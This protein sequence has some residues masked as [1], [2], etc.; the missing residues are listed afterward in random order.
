MSK[1]RTIKLLSPTKDTATRAGAFQLL[2]ERGD[3]PAIVSQPALNFKQYTW[4]LSIEND[5]PVYQP[6][7]FVNRKISMVMGTE[8]GWDLLAIDQANI[9]NPNITTNLSY[10]WKKNDSSIYE[11]NRANG[12]VGS[13]DAR[14]PKADST[15]EV[16][17]RYVCEVANKFGSVTSEPFDI[18]VIDLQN[19]PKLYTN[20]ILNGDG[21]GGTDGWE[22]DSDIKTAA[23]IDNAGYTHQFGSMPGFGLLGKD[24]LELGG[25]D[26]NEFFFSSA[27][28]EGLFLPL[29]NKRRNN[30]P[31]FAAAVIDTKKKSDPAKVLNVNEQWISHILPQIISNEDYDKTG[32]FAAFFPGIA[33]LDAYNKNN[34]PNTIS[35]FAEFVNSNTGRPH[36]LTYFTRERIKFAKY[37]GKKKVQFSQTIDVSDLATMIDGQVLGVQYLS[38]HF[39]A[40]M[41]AGLSGYNITMETENDGTVTFPYFIAESEQ[42]Y[43]RLVNQDSTAFDSEVPKLSY[44]DLYLNQLD[45]SKNFADGLVSVAKD[46]VGGSKYGNGTFDKESMY[47]REVFVDF[48][49][50]ATY[51]SSQKDGV[52]PYFLFN[53]FD[54]HIPFLEPTITP[55]NF[56]DPEQAFSIRN[57][58]KQDPILGH[59]WEESVQFKPGGEKAFH[60]LRAKGKIRFNIKHMDGDSFSWLSAEGDLKAAVCLNVETRDWNATQNKYGPWTRLQ[61]TDPSKS[62]VR[63]FSIERYNDYDFDLQFTSSISAG[64]DMAHPRQ[65]RVL[66]TQD[67]SPK[68]GDGFAA[69]Q[70]EGTTY[71]LKSIARVAFKTKYTDGSFWYDLPYLV[72]FNDR[73]FIP[74]DGQNNKAR[75]YKANVPTY[76]HGDGTEDGTGT[77]FEK[78]EQKVDM[79]VNSAVE[80]YRYNTFERKADPNPGSKVPNGDP[81]GNYYIVDRSSSVYNLSRKDAFLLAVRNVDWIESAFEGAAARCAA[82]QGRFSTYDRYTNNELV[83][84]AIRSF[85]EYLKSLSPQDRN[86][87]RKMWNNNSIEFPKV[88]IGENS[89]LEA[90][91]WFGEEGLGNNALYRGS[92]YA[93]NLL[94]DNKTD[95]S[96]RTLIDAQIRKDYINYFKNIANDLVLDI[97]TN[98]SY[99]TTITTDKGRITKSYQ[100]PEIQME[101]LLDPAECSWRVKYEEFYRESGAGIGKRKIK[102]KPNTRI[103]IEP[104]VDDTTKVDLEYLS[105]IGSSLKKVTVGGPTSLDVWAIKEKVF[106]PLTLFPLFEFIDARF[107]LNN[108]SN[109]NPIYVFGQKFTDTRALYPWLVTSAETYNEGLLSRGRDSLNNDGGFRAAEGKWYYGPVQDKNARF[110]INN[111][112]LK[113]WGT[114]FPNNAYPIQNAYKERAVEDYG[115]AAMFGA[116]ANEILPLGTRSIKVTVTFDHES[117]LG[118]KDGGAYNDP[119]PEKSGWSDQNIYSY[120][121]GNQQIKISGTNVIKPRSSRLLE[122]G[123]PRCGITKLKFM[124][125]PNDIIIS[126]KYATYQVPPSNFTVLG[127]QKT[128]I[129]SDPNAFDSTNNT[130][131]KGLVYYAGIPTGTFPIIKPKTLFVTASLAQ[132]AA[133]GQIRLNT[134]G[135]GT[136]GGTSTPQRNL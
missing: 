98:D 72:S 130:N 40:Y 38:S 35:L 99:I 83:A 46:T 15:P 59:V 89:K 54:R 60:Y 87:D 84:T 136:I 127:L 50:D 116:S 128:K 30:D 79:G 134:G 74:G 5:Q 32:R 117:K 94:T 13:K 107:E 104:I 95:V 90:W 56:N 71:D 106:F 39:F 64:S 66:I 101:V 119:E 115:A 86:S 105:D 63:N 73:S 25:N 6:V 28:H 132:Q 88:N 125:M 23:F 112:D 85:K 82:K 91:D 93:G 135:I 57:R 1:Q 69:Q 12:G 9:D 17:G 111:Y 124:L 49:R 78:R 110:I 37:G 42:Y 24:T 16:S 61:G 108:Y 67:S 36:P 96:D 21:D 114:T 7:Q 133:Q 68:S 2:D 129:T 41:G 55:Q 34:G 76:K 47:A 18:E 44:S 97:A 58:F 29:L 126:D 48:N 3:S 92:R 113:R 11:L 65:F 52:K 31:D 19:H 10:F 53:P 131:S 22:A 75:E 70:Y 118:F 122:Y 103:N 45:T 100:F 102:I 81:A 77:Y 80:F 123:N 14:L 20:L 4:I 62:E 109:N 26:P 33:W 8:F 51:N 120:L 43:D 27:G 121:F